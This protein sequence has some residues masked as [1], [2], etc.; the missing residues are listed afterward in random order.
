[1][2]TSSLRG[3]V[4]LGSRCP[5]NSIHRTPRPCQPS[6]PPQSDIWRTD[7]STSVQIPATSV[8]RTARHE[9]RHPAI[10]TQNRSTATRRVLHFNVTEHPTA[11]WTTQRIV[12]ALPDDSA[13]SY[14]LRDRDS[15]YGHVFRQ[16]LKGMG[17]GEVL[18]RLAAPGRTPSR[19][20]S[21]APS[22]ASVRITSSSSANSTSAVPWLATSRTTTGHALTCPSTRMRLMVGQSSS[23]NSAGSSKFTKSVAP[24]SLFRRAA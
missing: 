2:F 15:V 16:R 6:C 18:R 7:G 14:L 8:A 3:N 12:D 17:V 10:G 11:A 19:S 23:R 9:V 24:P 4:S 22:G 21:S 13:P 20:A 1:M 5:S